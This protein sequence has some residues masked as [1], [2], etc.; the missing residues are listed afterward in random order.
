M[1]LDGPQS[2]SGSLR[3]EK[4][5]LL[6]LIQRTVQQIYIYICVC[7]CVWVVHKD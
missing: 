6:G 4:I 5:S 1:G 3:E 7:V 2:W